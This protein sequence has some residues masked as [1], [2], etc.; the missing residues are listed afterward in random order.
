MNYPYRVS[1]G[2]TAFFN[3]FFYRF[4]NDELLFMRHAP[5]RFVQMGNADWFDHHA[6]KQAN[7]L[8]EP[9]YA[10]NLRVNREKASYEFMEPVVLELKLTNISDQPQLVDRKVL[11]P[12]DHITVIVKK[13][14]KSARQLLPFAEYCYRPELLA[15]P[16]KDSIYESLFVAVGRGGW[17]IAEPGDYTVQIALHLPNEDVVSNAIQLR[18]RPPRGYDEEVLAQD[19]FED[20]VGRTLNFDGSRSRALESAVNTLHEV[21][22]KLADRKVSIHAQVAL[23]SAEMEAYKQLAID[24]STGDPETRIE[25]AIMTSPADLDKAKDLLGKALQ[26]REGAAESLGHIDYNYY[27]SRLSDRLAEAGETREAKSVLD[28]AITTLSERNVKPRVIEKMRAKRDN[29]DKADIGVEMRA[30]ALEGSPKDSAK[31]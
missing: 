13:K 21:A 10:L 3:S 14:G 26:K 15:L 31:V 28:T 1:G 16:P 24:P 2:P 11:A 25:K 12:S 19:F 8:A 5:E 29:I 6:F 7:V 9:S 17:E 30:V 20:E 23:A 4:S 27:S 18:V 22:D